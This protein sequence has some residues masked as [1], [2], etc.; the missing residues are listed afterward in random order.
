[1]QLTIDLSPFDRSKDTAAKMNRLLRLKC[2]PGAGLLMLRSAPKERVSKHGDRSASF[3]TPPSA[4][5][6]D[7]VCI[8]SP[9]PARVPHADLPVKGT[10]G[11]DEQKKPPGA[12][13]GGSI[14]LLSRVR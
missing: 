5:P 6:Q 3:E 11:G 2:E 8:A 12:K 9:H 13:P 1:M 4:A 7:E 10:Y 14:S